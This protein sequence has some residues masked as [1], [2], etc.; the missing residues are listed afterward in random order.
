MKADAYRFGFPVRQPV[1]DL[2]RVEEIL[3]ELLCL[4]DEGS[5]LPGCLMGQPLS[6]TAVQL[7]KFPVEPREFRSS[8]WAGLVLIRDLDQG[9]GTL[10]TTLC[11]DSAV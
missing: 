10:S 6:S 11:A 7:V 4:P 9:A 5:S 3:D 2:L 8:L 1:Q